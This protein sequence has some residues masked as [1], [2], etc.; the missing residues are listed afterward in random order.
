MAF[1]RRHSDQHV[2]TSIVTV[3]RA[4]TGVT[5]IA[6][7]G[8]HVEVPQGTSPPYVKIAG[9][10]ASRRADTQGR[11]GKQILIDV[12]SI[13]QGDSQIAGLQ[14]RDAA[15]RALDFVHLTVSLSTGQTLLGLAYESDT[16]Y[17]E[18]VNAIKTHHH[19][20]SFR[21]WTEQSST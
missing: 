4:S 11:F 1:P 7:R 21:A 3:L 6:S 18:I 19:L 13:T 5:G 9:S 2:L 15:C 14:L 17:T 8:V 10:I 12:D 20:A 16:Y